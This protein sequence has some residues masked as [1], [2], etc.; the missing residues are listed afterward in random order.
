M[1]VTTNLKQ[2]PSINLNLNA[3]PVNTIDYTTFYT[4]TGDN[5]VISINNL[6]L[7]KEKF[8]MKIWTWL[9]NTHPHIRLTIYNQEQHELHNDFSVSGKFTFDPPKDGYYHAKV[10][11]SQNYWDCSGITLLQDSL[12]DIKQFHYEKLETLLERC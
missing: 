2:L 1:I 12:A 3:Q 4:A 8:K 5:I 6:H 7:N 10:S 11:I 9:N